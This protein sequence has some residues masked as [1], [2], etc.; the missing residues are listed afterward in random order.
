MTLLVVE[1]TVAASTVCEGD[2]VFIS[3]AFGFCVVTSVGVDDVGR[4]R[5]VYCKRGED[6]WVKGWY[7][8]SWLVERSLR[9]LLAGDLLRV[10][11]GDPDRADEAR[12]A[13]QYER[14]ARWRGLAVV[15][16]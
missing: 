2:E 7:R 15:D 11:R 9:P 14:E 16:G 3:E 6:S 12:L 1:S 8:T 10:R 13:M 4:V 5:V